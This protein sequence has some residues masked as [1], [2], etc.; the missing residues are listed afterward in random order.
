MIIT[1]EFAIIVIKVTIL[2]CD[3]LVVITNEFAIIIE[4]TRLLWC[5]RD[6]CSSRL[7]LRTPSKFSLTSLCSP[8]FLIILNFWLKINSPEAKVEAINS[9]IWSM[10]SQRIL[11][12][13]HNV[14]YLKQYFGWP[15]EGWSGQPRYCFKYITLCQPFSGR[16]LL[17]VSI[18][19]VWLIRSPLRSNVQSSRIFVH[20]FTVYLVFYLLAN[21]SFFDNFLQISIFLLK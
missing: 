17:I 1:N 3:G 5:S 12:G 16:W 10:R 18:F 8:P 21:K 15:E 13:W 20:G 7:Y 14:I 4:V 2:S 6:Y 11:Q 19:E 9:F